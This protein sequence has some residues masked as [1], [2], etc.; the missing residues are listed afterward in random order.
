MEAVRQVIDSDLLR[1]IIPLPKSFQSKKIEI[2]AFVREE[3]NAP[4]SFTH[5]DIDSMLAG[6]VTESLIGVLPQ[7][8]KSLDDYRAERLGKYEAVN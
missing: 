6:S 7:S 8:S 1:G 2:I 5:A 3:W 4:P